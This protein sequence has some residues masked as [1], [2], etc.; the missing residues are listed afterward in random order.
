VKETGNLGED[1]LDLSTLI[2]TGKRKESPGSHGSLMLCTNRKIGTFLSILTEAK[3]ERGGGRHAV[4]VWKR[5][6]R[7]EAVCKEG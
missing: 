1:S 5:E 7:E 4:I 3:G 2:C 6:R